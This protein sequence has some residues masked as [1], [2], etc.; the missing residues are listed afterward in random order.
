[1]ILCL[2]VVLPLSFVFPQEAA[3]DGEAEGDKISLDVGAGLYYNAMPL[4]ENALAGFFA[5]LFNLR[6]GAFVSGRYYLSEDMSVGAE[7]EV[8]YISST[9][10]VDDEEFNYSLFDIPILGVFRHELGGIAA[11]PFL[12]LLMTGPSSSSTSGG[13]ETTLNMNL[14]VGANIFLGG[15]FGEAGYVIGLGNAQS[16]ARFGLGYSLRDIFGF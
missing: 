5:A 12:G 6:G 13:G 2:L 15:L 16:F 14:Y 9:L 4:P 10:T 7:L 3:E 1:M 11:Q 8:H